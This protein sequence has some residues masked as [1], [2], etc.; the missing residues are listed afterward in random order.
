M[1]LI[2]FSLVR[3]PYLFQIRPEIN[4]NKTFDKKNQENFFNKNSKE[5]KTPDIRARYWAYLFDNLKRAVDEIYQTCE[6]DDSISEC[7]V[8]EIL[9]IFIYYSSKSG[10]IQYN[11]RKFIFQS[12]ENFYLFT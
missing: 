3:N 9:F 6:H 11:K 12:N 5:T 7:K 8:I 2:Y 10:K 1:V 4:K